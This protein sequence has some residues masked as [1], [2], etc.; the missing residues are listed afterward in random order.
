MEKGGYIK[1]VWVCLCRTSGTSLVSVLSIWKYVFLRIFKVLVLWVNWIR[2]IAFFSLDVE[3]LDSSGPSMHIER[4]K[5]TSWKKKKKKLA[6][7]S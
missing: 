2:C 7:E 4:K 5:R 1:H 3:A 6:G